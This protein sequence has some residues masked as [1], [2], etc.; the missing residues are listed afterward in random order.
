VSASRPH[1]LGGTMLETMTVGTGGRPQWAAGGV[2]R[3]D[4]QL[5]PEMR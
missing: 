3:A 2:R 4:R 5:L 1:R